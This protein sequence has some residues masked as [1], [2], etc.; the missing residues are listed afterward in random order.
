M[1]KEDIIDTIYLT[2]C[3]TI[4]KTDEVSEFYNKE[5]NLY[6]YYNNI[7]ADIRYFFKKNNSEARFFENLTINYIFSNYGKEIITNEINESL[8]YQQSKN[9]AGF[10]YNKFFK[11]FDE[12]KLKKITYVFS[13]KVINCN[14][15]NKIVLTLKQTGNRPFKLPKSYLNILNVKYASIHRFLN[16]GNQL[17]TFTDELVFSK[18]ENGNPLYNVEIF[19]SAFNTRLPYYGC[20]F[21]EIEAEAGGIGTAEQI[22]QSILEKGCLSPDFLKIEKE[23]EVVG[24]LVSPPSSVYL[25]DVAVWNI[26]LILEKI[27]KGELKKI[28]IVLAISL[29]KKQWVDKNKLE[30]YNKK[31]PVIIKEAF[32]FETTP[33]DYKLI[34]KPFDSE[35]KYW[36]EYYF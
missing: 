34:S 19:G 24:I 25:H 13:T 32:Y 7:F 29:S 17:T 5:G 14:A 3:Y 1:I 20:M 11:I 36:C 10:N 33:L 26:R 2:S 30:I 12:R 8:K 16:P 23:T 28:N 35:N 31:S 27:A 6:T 22:F 9:S 18:D 15:D 4:H 21:P